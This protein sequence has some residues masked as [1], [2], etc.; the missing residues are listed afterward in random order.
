M[1]TFIVRIWIPSPERARELS[2][3]EL[4]GKIEQIGSTEHLPFRSS[5]ELVSLLRDALASGDD[6]QARSL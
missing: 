1:R 5:E 4:R 2:A 6:P 3:V